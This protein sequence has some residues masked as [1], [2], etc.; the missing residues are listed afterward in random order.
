[1]GTHPN[2][3]ASVADT[4]EPLSSWL[5]RHPGSIGF[6]PEKSGIDALPFMLKILSIKTALS[7]QV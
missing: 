2:G 1:M 6:N 3:P 5:D 7:I 4:G